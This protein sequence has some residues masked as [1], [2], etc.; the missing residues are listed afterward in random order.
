M[1]RF[2]ERI[3]PFCEN[4]AFCLHLAQQ[5]IGSERSGI[6]AEFSANIAQTN[7]FWYIRVEVIFLP[8]AGNQ[9]FAF[10]IEYN[11]I[12]AI[13]EAF[14]ALFG[15]VTHARTDGR[16]DGRT[17]DRPARRR[18]APRAWNSSRVRA[19]APP[20]SNNVI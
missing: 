11:G 7:A 9:L 6:L 10:F 17:E 19:S 12:L 3:P 13:L 14:W 5:N 18:P 20:H 2:R 1:V 16:T 4:D 15:S 8:Q